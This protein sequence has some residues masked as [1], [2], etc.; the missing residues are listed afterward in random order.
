MSHHFIWHIWLKLKFTLQNQL[1]E[2]T[3]ARDKKNFKTHMKEKQLKF[4]QIIWQNKPIPQITTI[5]NIISTT[6]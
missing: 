1:R 4:I 2:N 3:A 6:I 5:K